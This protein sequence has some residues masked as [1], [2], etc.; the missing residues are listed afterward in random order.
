MVANL[1]SCSVRLQPCPS[2]CIWLQR[3]QVLTQITVAGS[4]KHMKQARL[5]ILASC[6]AFKQRIVLTGSAYDCSVTLLLSCRSL[7]SILGFVLLELHKLH[8]FY[9][10]V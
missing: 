4:Y 2:G 7:A 9:R 10:E 6:K 3:K 8:D 5:Q 1:N